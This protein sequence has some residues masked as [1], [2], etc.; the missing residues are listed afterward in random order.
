MLDNMRK[1]LS[2]KVA[3]IVNEKV[4]EQMKES[5][6]GGSGYNTDFVGDL[7]S[8]GRSIINSLQTEEELL[9]MANSSLKDRNKEDRKK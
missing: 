8:I 3:E 5:G 2:I 4:Q 1:N 7:V 9:K 6:I